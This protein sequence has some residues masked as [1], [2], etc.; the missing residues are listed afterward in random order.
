MNGDRLKLHK[1]NSF[2]RLCGRTPYHGS[3]KKRNYR[4]S[5]HFC[6]FD[7]GGSE[8]APRVE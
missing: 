5:S 2:S 4:A 1:E 3:E 6:H 7:G 8:N